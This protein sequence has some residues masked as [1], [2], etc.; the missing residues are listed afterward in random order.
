MSEEQSTD[1]RIELL[2]IVAP[3]FPSLLWVLFATVTIVVFSSSISALLLRATK[4]KIGG[5]V[6]IESQIVKAARN[7]PDT[8]LRDADKHKK[9]VARRWS[10]LPERDRPY[11][12]LVAHDEFHVAKHLQAALMEMGLVADVGICPLEI[13]TLLK[14]HMYDLVISDVEWRCEPKDSRTKNG[15]EFLQYAK[16]NRFDR[17]TIFYIQN[18][19]PELGTPPFAVGITNQWHE[20]LNYVVDVLSRSS[21]E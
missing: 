8:W 18:Y 3:V 2:K 1:R 21:S 5:T 15:I 9:Q 11:T 10:T 17:P 12:V 20:V 16:A 14:R 19:K 7:L 6:E 4:V 13:E